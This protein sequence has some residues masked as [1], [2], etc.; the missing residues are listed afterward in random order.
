MKNKKI[1][2]IALFIFVIVAVLIAVICSNLRPSNRKIAEEFAKGIK[3]EEKL[4]HFIN[5]YFDFKAIAAFNNMFAGEE[6][7]PTD[8][9]KIEEEF[10]KNY[11]SVSKEKINEAKEEMNNELLVML[12]NEQLKIKEIKEVNNDQFENFSNFFDMFEVTYIANNN[13][14]KKYDFTTYNGKIVF[15][16]FGNDENANG[17]EEATNYNDPIISI[18]NEE[19][20]SQDVEKLEELVQ[21]DEKYNNIEIE[22]ENVDFDEN[23][24]FNVDIIYDENGF[25]QK[26]IF[27]EK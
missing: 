12:T 22:Y 6:E 5:K 17:N 26:I 23:E 13:V 21:N 20:N 19:M 15:I 27:E 9:N 16:S 1:V 25:I 2:V 18:T 11:K 3:S 14:E 8:K 7:F 24:K 4:D 10:K